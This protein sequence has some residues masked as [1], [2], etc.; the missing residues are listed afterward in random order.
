MVTL[1]R[2]PSRDL[3]PWERHCGCPTCKVKPGELCKTLATR[4]PARS[5]AYPD[6]LNRPT[7]HHKARYD[8]WACLW[9]RRLTKDL[10]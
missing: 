9:G 10:T 4:Y 5:M 2:P 7:H 3:Y 8:L 6:M 1:G